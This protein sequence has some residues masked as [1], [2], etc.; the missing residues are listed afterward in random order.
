MKDPVKPQSD[1]NIFTINV[2]LTAGGRYRTNGIT[3][4]VKKNSKKQKFGIFSVGLHYFPYKLL[5]V[6]INHFETL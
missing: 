1:V 2:R 3:N 5:E 4:K 6:V